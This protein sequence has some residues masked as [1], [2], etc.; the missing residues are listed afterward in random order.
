MSVQRDSGAL[1]Q[2]TEENEDERILSISNEAE[3]D[4]IRFKVAFLSQ[5][6]SGSAI[7]R[8]FYFYE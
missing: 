1:S 4:I 6:L 2:L 8:V 7:L 5:M 3:Q